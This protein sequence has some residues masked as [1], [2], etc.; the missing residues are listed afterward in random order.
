[1]KRETRAPTGL[2]LL[3]A[4]LLATLQPAGRAQAA[5]PPPEAGVAEV[6][7]SPEERDATDD[8]WTPQRM[9]DAIPPPMEAGPGLP[10][11][12]VA[13]L[14]ITPITD[15]VDPG[16][17]A[18]LPYRATGKVFYYD[19]VAGQDFV[20][21]GAAVG[22]RV[23]LTAG[24]CVSDGAGRFH[25]NWLFVP[26][27]RNGIEPRGRWAAVHLLTF[28]DWHRH[29]SYCRDVGFAVVADVSGNTLAAAVGGALQITYNQPP[30]HTWQALGYPANSP[31][32]GQLMVYTDADLLKFL[33]PSG[34]VTPLPDICI[35]SDMQGGS[36][37]GPWL[38]TMGGLQVNGA[39]SLFGTSNILCSP[40]FDAQVKA[41]LDRALSTPI[42][43]AYL[44]LIR[45]N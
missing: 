7:I 24:H 32:D 19:P 35:R 16:L 21:S 14:A 25:D 1:M 44:P 23:V 34:C 11:P 31:F 2:C 38:T 22:G 3:L 9:A 10:A 5:P 37:G 45:R 13:D 15:F 39:T 40:T 8:Y 4:I 17:Y 29:H 26:A 36:S 20:C 33:A 43:P 28:D 41:L 27:Y 6:A 18:T 30:T 12:A 42:Y